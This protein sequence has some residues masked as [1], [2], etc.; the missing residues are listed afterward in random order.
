MK[1]K[2]TEEL[3]SIFKLYNA[4]YEDTPIVCC[5][6]K[7]N[8]FYVAICKGNTKYAPYSVSTIEKIGY[9]Y[10]KRYDLSFPLVTKD[11]FKWII[12]LIINT[13]TK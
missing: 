6:K 3:N 1:L 10:I 7:Y 8:N 11:A 12:R 13:S 9:N 5:Y 2:P 4:Y